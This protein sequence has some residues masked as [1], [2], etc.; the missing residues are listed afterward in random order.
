MRGIGKRET[1]LDRDGRAA[2]ESDDRIGA[3]DKRARYEARQR[4]RRTTVCTSEG[5]GAC[6]LSGRDAAVRQGARREGSVKLV[7]D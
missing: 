4:M 6:R 5:A 2:C 3:G 1:D 7:K